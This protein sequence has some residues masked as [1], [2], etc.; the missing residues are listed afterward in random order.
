MKKIILLFTLATSFCFAQNNSVPLRCATN[1]NVASPILTDV[2]LP[3]FAPYRRTG[4]PG[5]N[6]RTSNLGPIST[7]SITEFVIGNTLYD[8]QSNRGPARRI[9]NN[10]DGTISAAFTFSAN[11][12]G[13]PDRGTGYNYY[14][15]ASWG[16]IPTTRIEGIR[17]GFS[18][19]SVSGGKEFT[20]AHNGSGAGVL[21]SRNK[22]S[23]S[24][25]TYTPVGGTSPGADVWWRLATGGANG[26]TVHAIVNSQGSGTTPVLGQNGPLTYSRSQNG[27]TTWDIQHAV[28]PGCDSSYYEGFSTENYSIDCSGNTVVIASSDLMR[29]V[30]MWKS[31]DN[32]TT[33]TKTIIEAA[34]IAAYNTAKDYAPLVS[35]LNG[36]GI[37]DTINSNAGD[38]NVTL[39][40]NGM[41]HATWSKMRCLDDDTTAGTTIGGIFLTTAGIKYWNEGMSAP[42]EVAGLVDQNGDGQFTLPIGNGTDNPFGRYGNGGLTIHP[43]IGFDNS[44]NVF[45]A[46]SAVSEIT[47]TINYNAALRHV[48]LTYSTDM[49]TTWSTPED[50][51]PPAAQGGDGEYQEC[52]WPS[53]AKRNDN[54]VHIVYHRDP[55]P[56]YFV[57]NTSIYGPQNTSTNDIVYVAWNNLSPQ[58]TI[59]TS[60]PTT[61]CQG[62]SVIL[63]ASGSMGNQYLWSNGATSQSI[64]VNSTGIY[65]CTITNGTNSY[66]TTPIAVSVIQPP[67]SPTVTASGPTTFC[68]GGFVTLTSSSASGNTWSNGAITQSIIVS[69]SGNYFVTV[70]NGTCS[71]TS[72]PKTIVV[73]PTPTT[74]TISTTGPTT[75]CAGGTVTLIS[76]ITAGNTWSNGGTSQF[77]NV[78]TPGNYTVSVTDGTCT[79]TS[80]PTTIIVNNAPPTPTISSN[81]PTS[82]CVGGSVTLISSS[83]TGNTWSNGSTNQFISVTSSGNY[84]VTVSNGLCSSTSSQ[85]PV[86]VSSIP[87][88]PTITNTGATTFCAGG[89]VTLTSSSSTGNLWSTGATS[90]SII[91]TTAGTYS[92]SVSNGSCTSGT[93]VPK[94]VVVNP[95]PATPTVTANGPTTFCVGGSVTLSSSSTTGN[96]WS[97]GSNTQSITVTN[98]GNYSVTVSNGTCTATSTA[99]TVTRL[100]NPTINSQPASQSVNPNTT[101]QF[102]VGSSSAGISYQWQIDNGTGF[103][104]IVNGGQYAGANS[105]TLTI[106]GVLNSQNNYQYRCVISNASCNVNSNAATLTVFCLNPAVNLAGSNT[107]CQGTPVNL[108]AANGSGYTY[109][110]YRNGSVIAGATAANYA[111]TTAGNYSV[112][113]DSGGC[114]GISPSQAVSFY[115]LPNVGISNS[116]G[117][118]VC[119]GSPVTL[120]GTGAI[121]Y[122]W[123]NGVVNNTTIYPT[124]TNTYQVIGTDNNGCTNVSSTTISVNGLP[125]VQSIIGNP[126]IVPFQ[127]YIY[128][129]NSTPGVSFNWLIQG[130][131]IQSGQGT[132]SVNVIWGSNGPYLLQLVQS[133]TNGCSDTSS[134]AVINSNC[135]ITY[136]VQQ[137]GTA[138]YCQGDSITLSVA[139]APGTQFQWLLNGAPINNAVGSS[140]VAT[141]SGVYQVQMTQAGC[142]ALSNGNSITFLQAPATPVITASG[143]GSG[144]LGGTQSLSCPAGYASYLWNNG[145]T[146]TSTIANNSGNYVVTVTGANG[147]E[148][149]SS[150][151]FVNLSLLSSADICLVSVDDVTN[152]NVV[153]WEKPVLTGVDSFYVYKEST[154][155]NVYTK[156]GSV[157]ANVFSTFTDISSNP[158]QRADRYKISILDTCG[159]E[160]SPSTIHKSIHLSINQGVGNTYNLIWDAYEGFVFGTYYI[161]RGTTPNNLLTIDS[162]QSNLLSYTDLNPPAGNVYYAIEVRKSIQCNPTARTSSLGYASSRSNI[163][164]NALS[165]LNDYTNPFNSFTIVP[166]PA[167]ENTSVNLNLSN[168][169]LTNISVFDMTGRLVQI[170][171]NSTLT[172]GSHSF[173]WDLNENNAKAKAGVY[174]IK[175]AANGYTQTKRVVVL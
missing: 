33:W 109:Q 82:F 101:I 74:P 100:N 23:G 161:L 146:T 162:I 64:T 10:G 147:C 14:N 86:L 17:T 55:T 104:N 30:V 6:T 124:S 56:E 114:Y 58:A 13:Y 157:A 46:Y 8:L 144:C 154:S 7:T 15:G 24:W 83:A 39:D 34:P 71:A 1:L 149:T 173:T 68:N 32:G 91:V 103:T 99:V 21:L 52:V 118:V 138:P 51:V 164:D 41:V 163:K 47:D 78:S 148:A 28:L 38:I 31:T 11:Q 57:N 35:D 102:T 142:T 60:G 44:N 107:F 120:N 19:I 89:S 113:I 26:N 98:T 16:A 45:L 40:N 75:F 67:N 94:T 77:I 4:L 165:S 116:A 141:Q 129:V 159:F 9:V 63:S 108:F 152:K 151:F 136:T 66:T 143:A 70:S 20:L 53:I 110:W 119:S 87:T 2:D 117:T 79:A 93:S 95:I 50:L 115:G 140:F 42:A 27:G 54:K 171:N 43:Q 92:V 123:N 137:V 130:G 139:T 131:F 170:L 37:A 132:N 169:S 85:T 166:N 112:R 76:S 80:N 155:S 105:P 168:K 160:S 48:F 90:Q 5:S 150:P 88:T 84:S 59:T 175:I 122:S 62:G 36:D 18:N 3:N 135:S 73:N 61:F 96:T 156:I 128:G 126:S 158:L 172:A 167:T 133:N 72:A 49:G 106:S 111:A 29:D 134:L 145:T 121:S 127:N 81:G 174:L 125:S 22:G 12:S 65:L 25:T 153:I 97:N 69:S